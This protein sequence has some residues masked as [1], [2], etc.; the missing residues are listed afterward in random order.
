MKCTMILNDNTDRV[1]EP[2]KSNNHVYLQQ[3]RN[4]GK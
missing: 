3:S 1:K 4:Q 2:C